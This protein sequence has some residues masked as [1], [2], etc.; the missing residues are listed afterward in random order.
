V[1]DWSLIPTPIETRVIKI[2]ESHQGCTA[3]VNIFVRKHRVKMT[4]TGV[5]GQLTPQMAGPDGKTKNITQAWSFAQLGEGS[6][7]L[8][9]EV[10]L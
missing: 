3:K 1:S 4:L 9:F 2:G 6:D 10:I 8:W 5:N 7:W